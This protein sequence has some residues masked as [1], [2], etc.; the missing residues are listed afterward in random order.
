MTNEVACND[1]KCFAHGEVSIRGAQKDGV[2]VSAKARHTAI[3]QR[4][5]FI[6]NNKYSR[7]ERRRSRIV[8]HNPPC[9]AAV[10]GDKVEIGETRRLSKSKSWTI[11]KVLG[12]V[13]YEKKKRI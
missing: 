13:D 5:Y 6:Y 9:V 3:V 1:R 8:C 11:M 10:V 7:K 4:D 12:K 2:V